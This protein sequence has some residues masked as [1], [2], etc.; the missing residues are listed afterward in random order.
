M[1]AGHMSA[2]TPDAQWL[3]VAT[4]G[5]RLAERLVN[6]AAGGLVQEQDNQPK[7]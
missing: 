6:G 4:S 3:R 5:L 7:Q 1:Q 2:V